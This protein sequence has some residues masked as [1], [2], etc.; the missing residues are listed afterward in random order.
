LFEEEKKKIR[1]II[2]GAQEKTMIHETV[3]FFY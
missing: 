2:A 1:G 3:G